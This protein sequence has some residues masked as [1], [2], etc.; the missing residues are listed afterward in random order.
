[1]TIRDAVRRRLA[2]GGGLR[3]DRRGNRHRRR[4]R[5]LLIVAWWSALAG[6]VAIALTSTELHLGLSYGLLLV[7]AAIGQLWWWRL[8]EQEVGAD[9][10]ERAEAERRR[11]EERALVAELR[12]AARI[13]TELI[14][15]VGH[16]FRTPLTAIRGF[17][18]TLAF[19]GGQLDEDTVQVCL[20]TIDDQAARL[21]RIVGN[22]LLASD[23]HPPPAATPVDLS[24]LVRGV[25]LD[26]QTAASADGHPISARCEPATLVHL[27]P[28]VAR[29]LVLNLLDNALVFG[30]AASEV[31]LRAHRDGT[32]VLLEIANRGEPLADDDLDR[33]FEPFVQ[34]DSSD[35]RV[36][37]GIGL[38]L[39]V[40]RRLAESHGGSAVA[41]NAGGW[42][43]VS[44]RLPAAHAAGVA[45]LAGG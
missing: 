2:R 32:D 21:E 39:H 33:I 15:V 19:R 37:G 9:H 11:G 1:M 13:R 8:A 30:A 34:G 7:L 6:V 42:V 18:K 40:V 20:Q 43:T 5:R 44:V 29:A 35:T 10:A 4:N 41:S 28:E 16:E 17:A 25:V 27:H 22:V 26:V 14:A 38:G 23:R 3:G 12:E 24:E 45:E 36:V 31:L